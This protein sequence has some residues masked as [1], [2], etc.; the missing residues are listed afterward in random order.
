[1]TDSSSSA[2]ITS[3]PC[4]DNH[5]MHLAVRP[6]IVSTVSL[7]SVTSLHADAAVY[8]DDDDDN[9]MMMCCRSAL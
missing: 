5:N 7:M 6:Q 8:A 9:M 2:I 4:M 1:M 3:S